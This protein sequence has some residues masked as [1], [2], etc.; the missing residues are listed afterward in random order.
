[1]ALYCGI[2]LHSNNQVIVV[3]DDN[4]R[5]LLQKRVA[6]D[7]A[8]TLQWLMPWREQL[9]GVAVESTFNWY[10]LVDGLMAE[11]FAM[12]LVNTTKVQSYSGLKHSDDEHD[13][14]WLAHLMRLGILPTGYIYPAEQR[15]LR[16]LM[17][18]RLYL[19]QQRSGNILSLQNQVWRSHGHK[20]AC[21]E[22]KSLDDEF[23]KDEV[24][25][26]RQ[27]LDSTRQ[28]IVALDRQIHAIETMLKKHVLDCDAYR[29]LFSVPGIGFALGTTILLETGDIHRFK[30]P[31][32]YAS[33]SRCVDSVHT[34]NNKKKGE[35]N[36]KCGNRYL[37]WAYV[38]AAN[39]AKRYCPEAKRFYERK[40]AKT[41]TAI[42]TKALAHKLARAC[43]FLIRDGVDFDVNKCFA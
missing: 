9:C 30:G 23:A 39:F 14:F 6:N 17:R 33:Y 21:N 13:A 37:A 38:E 2:D 26:L 20:M 7:L 31:G 24:P 16:D 11:G 42:A 15:P 10:W 12:Q 8:L 22:I 5:I 25:L 19:V 34:S 32:N 35:G 1:M 29:H 40:K 3:I 18:R 41:N 43:F 28:I 4:D 36:V 27:S